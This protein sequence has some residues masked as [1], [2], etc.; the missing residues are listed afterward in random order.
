LGE[1]QLVGIRFHARSHRLHY[2]KTAIIGDSEAEFAQIFQFSEFNLCVTVK[3]GILI[4]SAVR[5]SIANQQ[6]LQPWG[7]LPAISLGLEAF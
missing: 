6:G 7:I 2:N 5:D 1:Q 3:R 4:Q